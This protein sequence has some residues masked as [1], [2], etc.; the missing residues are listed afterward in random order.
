MPPTM[1]LP[2]KMLLAIF[3]QDSASDDIKAT[4][5]S[6]SAPMRARKAIL[7][8]TSPPLPLS[9][10]IPKGIEPGAM[11]AMWKKPARHCA[12]LCLQRCSKPKVPNKWFRVLLLSGGD[13]EAP[14][15]LH[16]MPPNFALRSLAQR[17]AA[18]GCPHSRLGCRCPMLVG[19]A[20]AGPRAA[21]PA[22][23]DPSTRAATA[24][25]R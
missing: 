19:S 13:P 14:G 18:A 3:S 9:P 21:T 23:Q 2:V 15:I 11:Y 4:I 22:R 24:A 8:C 17:A 12:G 5:S 16:P 1:P 6:A 20:E 7:S 25:N 10:H